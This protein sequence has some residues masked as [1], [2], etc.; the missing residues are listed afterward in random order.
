MKFLND[1]YHYLNKINNL[2]K[3]L[4]V[5]MLLVLLLL[6]FKKNH[7]G[8]IQKNKNIITHTDTNIYDDFYANLYDILLYNKFKNIYE[9]KIINKN[10][11]LNKQ[12]YILDI[13]CGTGNH[14]NQICSN[15]TF[16]AKAIGLD[17]SPSMIKTAKQNYPKCKFKTGN[18]LKIIEF[19]EKTFTHITCLYFT[20]YYIKDKLTFFNNCYHWLKPKGTLTIHLVNIYKFDSQLDGSLKTNKTNNTNT[21]NTTNN[22]NTTKSILEF[23]DFKYIS[24]FKLNDNND[25]NNSKNTNNSNCLFKETFKFENSNKVR[26][27]EHKLFM[28]PEKKIIDIALSCGFTVLSIDKMKDIGYNY[29]YLYTLV[30]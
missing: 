9:L 4:I 27:N 8:F 26:I 19:E 13:G 16:G 28:I 3:F 1:L 10:K 24:E 30:K 25:S 21:T 20:I 2:E 11:S 17:I 5:L 29:N 23:D 7:E 22:T 15:D 12:S 6:L 18:A 14:I